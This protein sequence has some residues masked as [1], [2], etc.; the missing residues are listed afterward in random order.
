M[1][2]LRVRLVLRGRLRQYS[3]VGAAR[4]VS[5]SSKQGLCTV[6]FRGRSAG[7]AA[8]AYRSGDVISVSAQVQRN[9]VP[10]SGDVAAAAAA[11]IGVVR[12]NVVCCVYATLVDESPADEA[13]QWRHLHSKATASANWITALYRYRQQVPH[14]TIFSVACALCYEYKTGTAAAITPESQ[15][16]PTKREVSYSMSSCLLVSRQCSN[17]TS[18]QPGQI[19][20]FRPHRLSS[21]KQWGQTNESGESSCRQR[22]NRIEMNSTWKA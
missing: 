2:L 20:L 22:T 5:G 3:A 21:S 8:D 4:V 1:Y 7:A 19:G 15:T 17:T 13:S 11:A 16:A 10:G 6:G 18:D 12:N 9:R 14:N